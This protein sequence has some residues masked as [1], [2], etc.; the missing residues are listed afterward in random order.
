MMELIS[1]DVDAAELQALL[2]GLRTAADYAIRRLAIKL[3]SSILLKSF[4]GKVGA[5]SVVSGNNLLQAIQSVR[6]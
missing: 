2:E 5:A 3:S 6:Y 4:H 1:G